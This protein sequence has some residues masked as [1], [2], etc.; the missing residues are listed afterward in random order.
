MLQTINIQLNDVSSADGNIGVNSTA[1]PEPTTEH[2]DFSH[3]LHAES[4]DGVDDVAQSGEVLPLTGNSL[5]HYSEQELAELPSATLLT[6]TGAGIDESLRI[7]RGPVISVGTTATEFQQA[8]GRATRVADLPT[9]LR[10][11]APL[12]STN[13]NAALATADATENNAARQ[14]IRSPG[15]SLDRKTLIDKMS[16]PANDQR[17]LAR[18]TT[19]S[20][21]PVATTARL[22]VSPL[23]PPIAD[24]AANALNSGQSNLPASQLGL[25]PVIRQ[26]TKMSADDASRIAATATPE[27]PSSAVL[28]DSKLQQGTVSTGLPTV[29]SIQ[30]SLKSP[31]WSEQFGQRVMLMASNKLQ[32]AELRLHPAEMGPIKVQVTMDDG[33]TSV[34]FQAQHAVTRE[35][36]EQALPRLRELMEENGL[37]LQNASVSDQ[38]LQNGRSETEDEAATNIASPDGSKHDV[39]QADPQSAQSRRSS[40]LLDTFV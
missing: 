40:A 13:L 26:V 28:T 29:V 11:T 19:G 7:L 16:T 14:E 18:P 1:A 39:E 20:L 37:A 34:N 38:S 36:I 9:P 24:I 32:N 30:A 5:P 23:A 25:V 21:L 33:I 22:E 35:A 12:Q 6:M 4:T 17:V 3:T 2:S 10:I 27:S 15:L 31:Q 8:P